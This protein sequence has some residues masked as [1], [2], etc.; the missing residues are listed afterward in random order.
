MNA[1][2][3]VERL[4]FASRFYDRSRLGRAIDVALSFVDKGSP[5]QVK[6]LFDSLDPSRCARTVGQTLLAATTVNA[7]GRAAFLARYLED[8]AAR[9]T[10]S[11]TVERLR[12]GLVK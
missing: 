5:E 2:G 8:L 12:K 11:E 9:G 3:V 10:D 7:P 4:Y 6:A 1:G